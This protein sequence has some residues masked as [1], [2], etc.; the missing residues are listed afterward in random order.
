MEMARFEFK[1][2]VGGSLEVTLGGSEVVE[3]GLRLRVEHKGDG[4]GK[5][6][7]LHWAMLKG[8]DRRD[9]V[10]PPYGWVT[11]PDVSEDGGGGAW[12]TPFE[13]GTVEVHFRRNVFHFG[14][15][16]FVVL[17]RGSGVWMKGEKGENLCVPLG[18]VK[19]EI[20]NTAKV[21]VKKPVGEKEQV[22]NDKFVENS[23]GEMVEKDG[24]CRN[25]GKA[26]EEEVLPPAERAARK[27]WTIDDL[28]REFPPLPESVNYEV[29]EKIK[30]SESSAE[31][32]LLHRFDIV[33]ELIDMYGDDPTALTAITL[34]MRLFATRRVR[35]NKNYNIKPREFSAAQESAAMALAKRMPLTKSASVSVDALLLAIR[36]VGRGANADVG[37]GVR[38]EILNIQKRNHCK[39]RNRHQNIV[40]LCSS[41]SDLPGLFPFLLLSSRLPSSIAFFFSHPT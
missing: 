24:V 25:D 7:R 36:N 3:G 22:E 33:R 9:W 17:D 30:S 8:D 34:W 10:P 19:E 12:Q 39:V 11:R 40:L 29:L 6:W 18:G 41:C 13:K 5:F 27:E 28:K 2:N 38:D 15:V 1:L 26:E 35:W 21:S 32:S 14:A 4:D 23:D 16:T 31:R 37:Q 20:L